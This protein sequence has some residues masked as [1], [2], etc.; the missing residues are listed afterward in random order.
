MQVPSDKTQIRTHIRNYPENFQLTKQVVVIV[1][2]HKQISNYTSLAWGYVCITWLSCDTE[3]PVC[4][5]L[6]VA[7]LWDKN[8]IRSQYQRSGKLHTEVSDY[9]RS[10]IIYSTYEAVYNNM[11]K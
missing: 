6:K 2:T 7:T 1:P 5:T 4:W 11:T 8:S 9:V 3:K 10:T